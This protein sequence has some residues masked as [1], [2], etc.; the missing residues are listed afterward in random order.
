MTRLKKALKKLTAI[1]DN[2]SKNDYRAFTTMIHMYTVGI[3]THLFWILLFIFINESV[4]AIYNI[5]SVILF[6]VAI[7]W[8]KRGHLGSGFTIIIIEVFTH[9]VIATIILGWD[10]GFHYFIL[11]SAALIFFGPIKSYTINILLSC[12]TI[13][14]YS[15][16]HYYSQTHG[17][18]SE[19]SQTL[20]NFLNY[21]CVLI[22]L[23]ILSLG[24]YYYS[25]SSKQLEKLQEEKRVE[26]KKL[27]IERFNALNA[28]KELEVQAERL[29]ILR[30]TM[31]TVQDI[32]GNFLNK[33][34]LF[35]IEIEAKDALPP[36]T[37]E[38]MESIIHETSGQ[39]VKLGDLDT[40]KEKEL[41]GGTIGIDFESSDLIDKD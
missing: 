20:T 16:L 6:G 41:A 5:L 26:D 39:L 4:L 3:I 31:R 13:I 2:I 12:L 28:K 10:T 30:A 9:A 14:L 33:L 17:S 27:H 7:Y 18:L 36:E 37:L 22:A 19:L 8:T 21:H 25:S 34:Y 29:K 32:V 35:K 40:V 24:S 11:V 23:P 38:L 15:G 1:P